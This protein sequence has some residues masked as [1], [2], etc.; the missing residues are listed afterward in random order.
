MTSPSLARSPGSFPPVLSR[1]ERRPMRFAS[2]LSL[3][4]MKFR[5]ED[6]LPQAIRTHNKKPNMGHV[7]LAGLHEARCLRETR[8]FV[9]QRLNLTRP[10]ER[11]G[12]SAP[13]GCDITLAKIHLW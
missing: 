5:L 8:S 3:C 13:T 12:W 1:S 2:L 7:P 9:G 4:G 6:K 11:L 10:A